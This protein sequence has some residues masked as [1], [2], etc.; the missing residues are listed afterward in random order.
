VA[1]LTRRSYK[2]KSHPILHAATAVP[3]EIRVKAHKAEISEIKRFQLRTAN[4]INS[5]S[6]N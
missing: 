4:W 1:D 5:A 3:K 2:K 6:N